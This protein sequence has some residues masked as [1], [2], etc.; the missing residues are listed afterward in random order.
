MYCYMQDL[1]VDPEYQNVGFG[2]VLMSNIEGYLFASVKKGASIG[3]LSAN[4]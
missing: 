2:K 4:G 1:V 3:L